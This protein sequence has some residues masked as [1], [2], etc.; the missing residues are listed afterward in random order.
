MSQICIE[1]EHMPIGTVIELMWVAWWMPTEHFTYL[2][3]TF[4]SMNVH[5][6]G[7][8]EV[9]TGGILRE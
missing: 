3:E 9:E 2:V 4:I 5:A 6:I 8:V 1:D 7:A